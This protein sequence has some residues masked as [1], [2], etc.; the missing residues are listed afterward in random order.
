MA[1]MRSPARALPLLLAASLLAACRADVA[2][3]PSA[4]PPS[5]TP[6]PTMPPPSPT[7]GPSTPPSPPALELPTDAPTTFAEPL[8]P[9][10]IPSTA[11]TP[12]DSRV[13]ASWTMTPPADPIGLIGLAWARGGD[14]FSSQ[15]GFVVWQRFDGQ[16]P[17]WRAA[18][19]FTDRAA[20][21]ILGIR[22][23]V[24]D[25]THDGIDDVLT[26]EDAGGS[27]G[28]GMWRVISPTRGGTE[29]I[30]HK[31]TCDTE[32]LSS[33]G[34]LRITE[35]VYE[36]GDAHCCPSSFLIS[37]LRWS[38]TSWREVSARRSPGANG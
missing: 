37:I 25:L 10:Q 31:P 6:L 11:L 20:R 27:G 38:G 18:Y 2:G 26:F 14:P 16:A 22:L 32:I 1:A 19:A 30:F 15:H 23:S 13:T 24:G 36:P 17:A 3:A 21:G 34:T 8:D 4:S 35:A 9:A 5:P 7:T 29:Q 12:P 33:A 28:C